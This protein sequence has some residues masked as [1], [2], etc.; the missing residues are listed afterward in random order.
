[1]YFTKLA[2]LLASAAAVASATNIV[3][4]KS[5]D[6]VDRTV[7]F[8]PSAGLRE[9]GS[10]EVPAG[11][12]VDVTIDQGWIG[13]FHAVQAG[14]PNVPGM[15]G[16]VAFNGWNGLNYYDVSAIVNPGDVDNVSELYPFE[17]PGTPVSGCA[18]FPCNNAYYAP[19]DVQTKVTSQTHL[20][21]TLGKNSSGQKR[22][23]E[24]E[25]ESVAR[26]YVLGKR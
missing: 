5:T 3:T 22:D 2:A 4:F 12:T 13:N 10:V 1:M 17:D 21:C 19:D 6:S 15:L 20:V 23:V 26:D 24:P 16:E 7:Y 9:L 8:T 14:Q 18:V 25:S 11:Q